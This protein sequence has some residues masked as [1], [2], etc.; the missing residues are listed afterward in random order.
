VPPSPSETALRTAMTTAMTT[1]RLSPDECAGIRRAVT[2]ACAESGIVWRRIILFGSR[3]DP[4]RRGGDIDLLVEIAPNPPADTFRLTQ[5]LRLA[6]EDE[7]GEQRIDLVID[8]G[9]GEDVFPSLA[10]ERGVE[11][12]SNT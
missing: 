7:L 4:G 8:A 11:L 3:T 12:W 2:R 1:V 9:G 10:R 5:R 6:L